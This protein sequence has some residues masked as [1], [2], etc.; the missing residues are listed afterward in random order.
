MKRS[1][2]HDDGAHGRKYQS[3]NRSQDMYES[4]LYVTLIMAEKLKRKNHDWGPGSKQQ[5]PTKKASASVPGALY[6]CKESTGGN[7]IN[8]KKNHATF[9]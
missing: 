1:R 3:R 2:S 5:S 9:Q 8:C 6:K 7:A 4:G